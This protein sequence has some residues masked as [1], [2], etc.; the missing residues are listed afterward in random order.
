MNQ[1][2]CFSPSFYAHQEDFSIFMGH[3]II[4]LYQEDEGFFRRQDSLFLS[5]ANVA[6]VKWFISE[7]KNIIDGILPT[8]STE[9]IN[10][11]SQTKTYRST[12]NM[13]NSKNPYGK[14]IYMI[15]KLFFARHLPSLEQIRTYLFSYAFAILSI[16]K[17]WIR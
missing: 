13:C 15:N 4:C 12:K 8:I 6:A 2:T 16:R 17:I 3:N 11:E 10:L 1:T 14:R 5:N 7:T 9:S